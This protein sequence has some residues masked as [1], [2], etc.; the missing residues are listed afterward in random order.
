MVLVKIVKKKLLP[1]NIATVI[2]DTLDALFQ[3]YLAY[4][5]IFVPFLVHCSQ[6]SA[7]ILCVKV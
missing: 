6:I 3:C 2:V 5:L 7:K 4:M 1:V